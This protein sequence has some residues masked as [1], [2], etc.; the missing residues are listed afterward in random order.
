MDCFQDENFL[1]ELP[2]PIHSSLHVFHLS[3]HKG[4][5]NQKYSLASLPLI[6]LLYVAIFWFWFGSVFS[7]QGFCG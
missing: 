5:L 6:S 3:N 1:G 4:E 2:Y 7:R